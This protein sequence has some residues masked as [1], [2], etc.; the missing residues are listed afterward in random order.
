MHGVTLGF[1]I[2]NGPSTMITA[3]GL[4]SMAEGKAQVD[5]ENPSNVQTA[6]REVFSYMLAVSINFD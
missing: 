2:F 5:P 1:S 4:F 3:G 6:H